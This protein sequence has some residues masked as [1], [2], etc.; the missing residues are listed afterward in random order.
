MINQTH[1][2]LVSAA[3][4][5]R[6]C[7]MRCR[8]HKSRQVQKS[9]SFSQKRGGSPSYPANTLDPWLKAV[10]ISTLNR[11]LCQGC[12]L[13]QGTR[14]LP[15]WALTAKAGAGREGPARG[16]QAIEGRAPGN[17]VQEG[18]KTYFHSG[19]RDLNL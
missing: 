10:C 1:W 9:P 3:Q 7:E 6:G 11:G 16:T 14:L 5:L 4:K 2:R 8:G 18:G 15:C 12:P 19:R 17:G 13:S